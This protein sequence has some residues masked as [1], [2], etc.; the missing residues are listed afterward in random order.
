MI[1]RTWSP[2]PVMIKMGKVYQNL[3]VDV[4][5]TNEN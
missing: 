4:Q 5:P 2:R 1:S 3:M